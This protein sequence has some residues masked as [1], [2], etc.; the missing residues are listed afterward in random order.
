MLNLLAMF[1]MLETPRTVV[2]LTLLNIKIQIS[3]NH[4]LKVVAHSLTQVYYSLIRHR[5]AFINKVELPRFLQ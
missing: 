5:L 4:L 1:Q 3:A 2:S